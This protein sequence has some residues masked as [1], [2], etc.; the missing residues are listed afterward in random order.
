MISEDSPTTRCSGYES[1]GGDNDSVKLQKCLSNL[2]RY[3]KNKDELI[4]QPSDDILKNECVSVISNRKE[5]AN[6]KLMSLKQKNASKKLIEDNKKKE[7]AKEQAKQLKIKE[8]TERINAY[9]KKV[10]I[11]LIIGVIVILLSL[12]LIGFIIRK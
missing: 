1:T 4:I 11:S 7:Q 8:K 2:I 5:M 10:K 3:D 9:I 6:L 12:T